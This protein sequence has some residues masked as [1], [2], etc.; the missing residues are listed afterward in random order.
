MPQDYFEKLTAA[1]QKQFDALQKERLSTERVDST[2]ADDVFLMDPEGTTGVDYA[3]QVVNFDST[4]LGVSGG[5]G[6]T[7]PVV[8]QTGTRVS[9]SP[10]PVATTETDTGPKEG[11]LKEGPDGQILRFNGT[12]W[13]VVNASSTREVITQDPSQTPATEPAPGADANMSV[14]RYLESLGNNTLAGQAYEQALARRMATIDEQQLSAGRSYG[15]MYEQAKMSQSRRRGLSDTS[16]M[17]GGMEDQM[18]ARISA[19]EMGALGQIGMGRDQTV[20]GLELSKLDAPMQAFEEGRQIEAYERSKVM[21][22]RELAQA[23]TLFDQ[24]QSGWM[25]NE[26]GTWTNLDKEMQDSISLQAINA[27][28]RAEVLGEMQY[29]QAITTAPAGTFTPEQLEEARAALGTLGARYGELLLNTQVITGRPNTPGGGPEVDPDIDPEVEPELEPTGVTIPTGFNLQMATGDFVETQLKNLGFTDDMDL[30]GMPTDIRNIK[31][32]GTKF[33]KLAGDKAVEG[34]NYT[35]EIELVNRYVNDSMSIT[36]S[37]L[38]DLK[39]AGIVRSNRSLENIWGIT[40]TK[41]PTTTV[42]TAGA[43]TATMPGSSYAAGNIPS[44]PAAQP[45]RK[46]YAFPVNEKTASFVQ[47]MVDN[48]YIKQNEIDT[49]RDNKQYNLTNDQ[50]KNIGSLNEA[51]T[52][53]LDQ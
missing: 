42:G 18:G 17:T 34:Y 3:G 24:A 1:R 40:T 36:S 51:L 38:Q 49:T 26:D 39:D 9:T 32:L 7:T 10:T 5:T 20:R 35:D 2:P 37:E 33:V 19:A 11:D 50:I 28:Q 41:I 47:Y 22:D 31:D 16:G 23:Q 21:M 4:N 29:W 12:T 8:T 15:D 14:D 53:F 48:N 13:T 30:P 52:E 43:A 6:S 25:Q 44:V 27:Q 46:K 45:E